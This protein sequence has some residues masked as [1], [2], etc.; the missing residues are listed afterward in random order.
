MGAFEVVRTATINADPT[1]VHGLINDFHEW[2]AWS[3]WEELDPDMTRTHSGSSSGVGA[4]YAWRGNRK[5]GEGSMEI[6]GSTADSIVVDLH[7]VKPFKAHNEV[8]FKLTPQGSGTQVAWHMRGEQQGLWALVGKIYPM[9][10]MVGKDF[11]KGL[12]RL[13]VAAEA[14]P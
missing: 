14:K 1:R 6:T 7:F 13:K 5:A 12:A 9:D 2:P 4:K 8:E 3:P 11:E 10:K